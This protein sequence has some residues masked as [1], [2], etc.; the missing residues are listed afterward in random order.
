MQPFDLCILT[1]ANEVQAKGYEARLAEFKER[2]PDL[3]TE[4]LVIADP[5]GRR[6]GSGG[7]TL[8]VLKTIYNRAQK[9]YERAFAGR[10]ILVIHSGGDSRRLPA[11]SAYGKIFTPLPSPQYHT[12]FDII[13]QTYASLPGHPEGHVII[14]S[15][16]VLLN[17]SRERIYFSES[18]VTG[19]AYP[20]DAVAASHHGVFIPQSQSYD[21]AAKVRDFLQKPTPEILKQQKAVDYQQRVWVDTGIVHLA[22]DAIA[23]LL[24]CHKLLSHAVDDKQ[25]INLYDHIPFAILGKKEIPDAVQLQKLDF[26]VSLLPYCGFFHIGRSK[27]F[28]YNLF[29]LTQAAAEYGFRS[30]TRSLTPANMKTKNLF[31]YNSVIHALPNQKSSPA[32]I[33]NCVLDKPVF[34]EGDNILTG[35][36]AGT[37]SIRLMPGIGM[38]VLPLKKNKWTALLYGVEDHFKTGAKPEQNLFLNSPVLEWLNGH[39]LDDKVLWSKNAGDL[40]TARLFPICKTA[41][42]AIAIAMTMQH[43]SGTL[44][45]WLKNERQSLQWILRSVDHGKI[46]LQQ[47]EIEREVTL[48]SLEHIF[49]KGREWSSKEL[50]ELCPDDSTLKTLAER[51]YTMACTHQNILGQSRLYFLL[52]RVLSTAGEKKIAGLAPKHGITVDTCMDL[53]FSQ[54]RKA[55]SVPLSRTTHQNRHRIAI[56]SDEVVWACSPARLDFAGGWS[57]TPPYCLEQGGTVLNAAVTLNGQYPIQVIGKINFDH[58]IRINSIDLGVSR[59][60][61]DTDTLSQFANPGDWLSLPKAALW[62]TGIFKFGEQGRLDRLLQKLGGGIDLTLFS[63]LPAGSGLGTSS[64]LGAAAI[65]ALSRM[66]GIRLTREELFQKT[67]FLEQLMTTGGGWQDQIGG[68]VG[69]VKIIETQSGYEQLPRI[70][71]TSLPEDGDH[72]YLLYYTGIR[73]MAKNILRQVVSR[74]LDRDEEALKTLAELKTIAYEMKTA[75]DQREIPHFGQLIGSVWECNKRLDHGSSTEAIEQIIDRIA[76]FVHGAKL[77]GAGGGGFLFIVCKGKNEKNRILHDLQTHPIND[78][79]RFFDF[80]VDPVGLRVNV[81]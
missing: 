15:G 56:R 34:L 75:L 53:S 71:W 6:I 8:Y 5:D 39:D 38:T 73:R 57:D 66:F 58:V 36:P 54:I 45:A 4:F 51:L 26:H 14:T 80:A 70:R 52:S 22:P 46:V 10:R 24:K 18:G 1:A 78:R 48:S 41:K 13:L 81:L 17:F 27:E 19:V 79:A 31:I 44:T 3:K 40:W 7:S 11:Y 43:K 68:V 60:I 9:R 50:I 2:Q 64:I 76:P 59:V 35:V 42:Q 55:V 12:V 67:S 20:D 72:S 63:A 21:S 23:T 69:G 61:K 62:A 28:L 25:N 16:D 47:N 49:A 65:A 32:L 77:L 29:T 37:D 33:E 30:G 74:Y